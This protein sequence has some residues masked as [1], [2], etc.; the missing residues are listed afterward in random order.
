MNARQ[1]G[2]A[3]LLTA[4]ALFAH[5]STAS[6]QGGPTWDAGYPLKHDFIAMVQPTSVDALGT[7][8]IAPGWMVISTNFSWTTLPNG[9]PTGV[10]LDRLDNAAKT[11][12]KM[13]MLQNGAIVPFNKL[14]VPGGYQFWLTV[15]YIQ[16]N[17]PPG[18]MPTLVISQV[19]PLTL[20]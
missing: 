9:T 18:T 19:V 5:T 13:G 20:K 14:M 16:I 10:A 8:T 3:G 12:G 7:Y 17:A 15:G 4:L 2:L 6:A 1:F 11:G